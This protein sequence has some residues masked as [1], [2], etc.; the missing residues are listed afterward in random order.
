MAQ[1]IQYRYVLLRKKQK[2][3]AHMSCF[4]SYKKRLHRHTGTKY[5]ID[6]QNKTKQKSIYVRTKRNP[7]RIMTPTLNKLIIDIDGTSSKRVDTNGSSSTRDI[8]YT[9]THHDLIPSPS[10]TTNSQ[11]AC[12]HRA[13]LYTQ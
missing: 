11:K 6:G 1:K 2:T 8:N 5:I 12:C 3:K 7:N 4:V 13:I 10:R 9:C